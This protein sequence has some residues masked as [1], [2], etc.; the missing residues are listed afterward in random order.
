MR[1]WRVTYTFLRFLEGAALYPNGNV[2][3]SGDWYRPIDKRRLS[4]GLYQSP[5]PRCH[6][7]TIPHPELPSGHGDISFS[8]L[9]A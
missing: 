9:R 2:H 7:D 4:I 1:K 8:S 3:G 5:E 6:S